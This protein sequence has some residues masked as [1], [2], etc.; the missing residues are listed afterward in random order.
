MNKLLRSVEDQFQLNLDEKMSREE[1]EKSFRCSGSKLQR[2]TSSLLLLMLLIILSIF[3]IIFLINQYVG[4]EDQRQSTRLEREEQS[5][6]IE[7]QREQNLRLA[8]EQREQQ[9]N[10]SLFQRETELKIAADNRESHKEILRHQENISLDQNRDQMKTEKEN[11]QDDIIRS[12][13]TEI[14]DLIIKNNETLTNRGVTVTTVRLKTLHI[15]KQLDAERKSFI[16]EFLHE[17]GQLKVQQ[18]NAPLDLSKANLDGIDFRRIRQTDGISLKGTSLRHARFDNLQLNKLDLS[19]TNLEGAIFTGSS[20]KQIDFSFSILTDAQFDQVTVESMNFNKVNGFGVNFNEAR[21]SDLR[22]SNAKLLNSSFLNAK[23]SRIDIETSDFSFSNWTRC[24]WNSIRT[25]PG[26]VLEHADFTEAQLLGVDMINSEMSESKLV[27]VNSDV[28]TFSRTT[29]KNT[30]F[31]FMRGVG[32]DFHAADVTGSNFYRANLREAR[33]DDA[34]MKNVNFNGTNLYKARAYSKNFDSQQLLPAL[35]IY[36]MQ[37]HNPIKRDESLLRNG[38]AD[39]DQEISVD[40]RIEGSGR[41]YCQNMT[42]EKTGFRLQP[43][44]T[45]DTTMSQRVSLENRWD[46]TYWKYA[47]LILKGKFTNGVEIHLNGLNSTTHV[48]IEETLCKE[49]NSS[50]FCSIRNHDDYFLSL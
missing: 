36:G 18:S 10:I 38:R 40:W 46:V 2:C 9:W 31:S 16:L 32:A 1:E 21:I 24:Q 29:M 7:I 27:K 45:E 23:L 26:C 17:N 35:S 5:R 49:R 37:M 15:L 13:L 28:V 34:I 41:V 47:K 43:Y 8:R 6:W 42:T 39:C 44:L 4:L 20:L 33:F 48:L 3:F 22:F 50:H 14:S 12:Y 11:Y 19:N 30:D 25:G